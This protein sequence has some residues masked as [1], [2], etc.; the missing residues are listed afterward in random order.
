LK[1]KA[2]L[3][4]LLAFAPPHLLAFAPPK[5]GVGQR[6]KGGVGGEEQSGSRTFVAMGFV[7]VK[8]IQVRMGLV[9]DSPVLCV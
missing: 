3:S 9:L 2:S 8:Q 6:P 1:K 4:H 7:L 5:G